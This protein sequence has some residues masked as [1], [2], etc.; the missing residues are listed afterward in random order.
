[1]VSR[2]AHPSTVRDSPL[3]GADSSQSIEEVVRVVLGLD[4]AQLVV[5]FAIEGS[6]EVWLEGIG[7]KTHQS[8]CVHLKRAEIM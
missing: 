3:I 4:C 2:T 1:M 8:T 6:L 7:L 5:I